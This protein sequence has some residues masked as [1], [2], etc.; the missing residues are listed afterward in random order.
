VTQRIDPPVVH[1]S[2]GL[3]PGAPLADMALQRSPKPRRR[4][5]WVAGI[6]V[7]LLG[8]FGIGSGASSAK[9]K[10]DTAQPAPITKTV[11]APPEVITRS[12]TVAPVTITPATVTVPAEVPAPA[13]ATGP[14]AEFGSGT[15]E[16]SIDIKAGKYKTSGPD[17][18]SLVPSCYW[19]RNKDSSGSFN[20]I[21]ANGNIEGPGT[22]TVKKGELFEVSGSCIWKL[23]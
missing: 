5:P 23:A 20:S 21:I 14:R 12:V 17:T 1:G 2:G 15:Y 4:W 16:V 6:V 13:A 22:V 10:T 3:E 18:S 9:P 7:A 8:G 19:A 11:T